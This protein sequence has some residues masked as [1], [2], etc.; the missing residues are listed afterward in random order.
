MLRRQRRSWYFQVCVAVAVAAGLAVCLP[1]AAQTF[2]GSIIGTVSDPAGAVIAGATVTAKNTATGLVRTT[3]TSSDGTYSI[4]ELT[5]GNYQV[6]ATKPGFQT[7]VADGVSVEV[8]RERHVDFTLKPGNV[9]QRVVVTEEAGTPIETTNNNLGIQFESRDIVDLPI[10]GRDI[11]KLYIM[12][13][14]V[15]GDPSGAG[16]SPG[17]YGQFSANGNR[18]RANNFLLDGT[19][20]NDS[21]RNLPA[22]N[23]GGVFAIPAT[24]LPIESISEVRVLTNFDA[25]YGRSSGSVVNIVTK[26]GTNDIHG[27]V[28]EYFRNS[29]LNARNFFDTT[30]PKDAFRNN[31]FGGAIG[32]PIVK[33]KT[34]FYGS[35]EGQREGLGLTSLNTVPA[36]ADYQAAIANIKLTNPAAN[37]ALCAPGA[38]VF[39]CVSGQP[40]GVIDPVILNYYNLCNTKRG[41][42]GGN[43]PWP[44]ANLATTPAGFNNVSSDT[45][46]NDVDSVILKVDHSLNSANTLTGRYFYGR[47]NQSLPL[48]TGG[49]N[50]IPNTNTV[51]PTNV[52]LASVSLVSVVSPTQT[53]EAR[54][55]FNRFHEGFFSQSAGLIGNPETSLGLNT[56]LGD[57]ANTI[58]G[59]TFAN[60]GAAALATANPQDYGLP[61]LSISGFSSLGSS[62]FANPRDRIDR[63]YQFVDNFSWKF[64]KNDVKM[65]FEERH[66]SVDSLQDL[67]FRGSL[68]F[69][70]TTMSSPLA[71]FLEG[72]V[73]GGSINYGVTNRYTHQD[74]LAFFIQDSWQ[75]LPRLTVNAGIRWDYYGV[76]GEGSDNISSYNPATGLAPMNQPYKPDW[77]NFGPRVSLAWDPFGKGKTVVRAGAAIFYDSFSF[78]YFTG[79]LY[80]NT[81]NLGPAYN[82]V[83]ADPILR[84]AVNVTPTVACPNAPTLQAG[85]PV[86][87][88]SAAALGANTTG[89][90]TV[91]PLQTPYVDT[92]TLNL[93]QELGANTVLQVGYVGTQGRKLQRIVDQN[94]PSLA[95]INAF[96]ATCAGG[97]GIPLTVEVTNCGG[98]TLPR[99][100]NNL[101]NGFVTLPGQNNNAAVLSALAPQTPFYLQQLQTSARS[102]YNALQ[103]T[104]TQRNWHG[105][106]QQINY[107]WSHTLDDAS[108]GQ[109]YV[110]HAGQPNDSTNPHF[111][112]Y[113]PSNV[114]VRNHF[115]WTLEYAFP[116]AHGLGRLGEGWIVSSVVTVQSG[117]PWELVNTVDDYDGSGEFFGRPDLVGKPVYNFSNPAEFLNVNVFA[118]QCTLSG[119][120]AGAPDKFGN[121]AADCLS[122]TR[123]FGTEGRNALIGPAFR[124]WDFSIIKN[125]KI[126]ERI[127]LQLRADAYNLLNHPNFS[128][129]LL[130]SFFD[131]LPGSPNGTAGPTLGRFSGFFPIVA[132]I[133]SGIGNPV[134]AGGGPRSI[135]FAAKLTF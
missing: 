11:D 15:T 66:T 100:F 103:V 121:L 2:R 13:P 48:G 58:K 110:P 51:S 112:N 63:N 74:S 72:N 94:Q 77:N 54:F 81:S 116:K 85:C 78:D 22:I 1:A 91:G 70:A 19:D 99:N 32:G 42:S 8:A 39:G 69:G 24:I 20:M 108:D 25:E 84:G 23:Q 131:A 37:P 97:L 130:P 61:S 124:Q 50:N 132:T 122:G 134:L 82:P 111:S 45:S 28:F 3:Q 129:P 57:V 75:I 41:C 17:S 5:V 120:G 71:N 107:T 80:E 123:H 18:D 34:F 133:D 98:T 87:A 6:T 88:T 64:A 60:C 59:T 115:I 47:S 62:S 31:Q 16:G 93:Q 101:G 126:T 49:G 43:S 86:F 36:L 67:S 30:G 4:P 118:A 46:H 55:G 52:N 73:T 114:D 40:A 125:T 127:S 53:N 102:N 21:Y 35:Y 92:F 7:A 90:S 106:T 117:H 56:C 89:A 113:G 33:N 27:S 38:T 95:A 44:V 83:G 109:D 10:N 104:L 14:G 26:S 79:Q 96:D 9:S 135:Q 12:S 76:I 65:G 29:V 128:N 105:I 119:L 68:S